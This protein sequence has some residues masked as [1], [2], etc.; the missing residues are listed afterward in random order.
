MEGASYHSEFGKVK[1]GFCKSLKGMLESP[2]MIDDVALRFLSRRNYTREELRRKLS[3]KGF[4]QS[5]IGDVLVRLSKRGYI[6]D[7]TTG[8]YRF[9]RWV[10]KG[11]GPRYI[12][13][14]MQQQGLTM[15]DYSD[16]LQRQVLK[17]LLMDPPFAGMERL[18]CMRKLYRRGF[19]EWM[20]RE[21]CS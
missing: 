6:D 21:V 11:Y 19:D 10:E 9:Q 3:L 4:G 2:L 13:V 12:A 14:K 5:E 18:A 1:R 20:V 8:S 7:D 16:A 15:P 17:G